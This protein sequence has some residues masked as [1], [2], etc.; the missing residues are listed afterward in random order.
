MAPPPLSLPLEGANACVLPG[1]GVK[2]TKKGGGKD[3]GR[4]PN[5]KQQNRTPK[6]RYKNGTF[7]SER[8]LGRI[9]RNAFQFE[10]LFGSGDILGKG[11]LNDHNQ[12]PQIVPRLCTSSV[13]F[14]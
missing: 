4:R 11:L 10:G 13:L 6:K 1:K 7:G 3:G 12:Q 2:K 8:V 5:E 14:W 9:V